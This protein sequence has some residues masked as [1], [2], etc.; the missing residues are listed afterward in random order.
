M[1]K[2][3]TSNIVATK[4]ASN[5]NS[6]TTVSGANSYL[7]DLYGYDDWFSLS[8]DEQ[9]SLLITATKQIDQLPAKYTKK[10]YS[11][12][13]RFPIGTSSDLDN[14]Y[15]DGFTKAQEATI[16]QAYFIY[17]TNETRKEMEMN[18]AMGVTNESVSGLSQTF[19]GYNR[20]AKYEP[21]VL[22]LLSSF[23]NLTPRLE[24]G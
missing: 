12:A 18:R 7:S 20:Y 2:P 22:R 11:Q 23:L 8:E 21:E 19:A 6:Y 15:D 14:T 17:Q 16:L 5:A 4:G 13:L 10:E 9:R 3:N 24:R 1:S